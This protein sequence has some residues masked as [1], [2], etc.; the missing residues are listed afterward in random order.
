[1][2]Q[3][4]RQRFRLRCWSHV[5]QRHLC[6]GQQGHCECA[7]Q[8]CQLCERWFVHDKELSVSASPRLKKWLQKLNRHSRKISNLS[9][10][11]TRTP[12]KQQRRRWDHFV[13]LLL[14][15]LWL[16]RQC[17]ILNHNQIKSPS[18]I[19]FTV[20]S[21]ADAIYNMVGYPDFIMNGTNLD[22]VFNDVGKCGIELSRCC[23]FTLGYISLLS[24]LPSPLPVW[25]GVGSLLPKRHAVLQLLSPSDR[26][27]AEE[28]SLQKPVS[29]VSLVSRQEH[30][31][32]SAEQR[33]SSLWWNLKRWVSAW[34][35]TPHV[36]FVLHM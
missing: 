8:L 33:C 20:W 3:W 2:C 9:A 16:R 32:D 14:I 31:P 6:W 34:L 25:G 23:N 30:S 22:K 11:W 1:M 15:W 21:Q 29:C 24:W 27:P 12:K 17:C 10:G 13:T 28:A 19:L 35:C 26:R 18:C 5:C 7:R 4:H 36:S